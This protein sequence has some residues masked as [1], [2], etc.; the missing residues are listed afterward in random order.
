MQAVGEG[1]DDAEVR[2]GAAHAPE[3]VG[4]AVAARA[5]D[6]PVRR[7]D[8][9]LEEVV[10]RPAEAAAE[11]AQPAAERE[12]GDADA[13]YVAERRGEAVPLRGGIDLGERAAGT[14]GGGPRLRVD[15]DR[16][17]QRH[18]ERQSARGQRRAADVVA[19]PA[20]GHGQVVRAGVVERRGDV[21][22]AGRLDDERGRGPGGAVPQLGARVEARRAGDEDGAAHAAPQ[23]AEVARPVDHRAQRA[24]ERLGLLDGR[25]V[26]RAV[27][28]VQRP[29]PAGTHRRGDGERR[30]EVVAAPHER[31]RRRDLRELGGRHGAEREL[32][33]HRAERRA[34]VGGARPLQVRRHER[35]PRSADRG[36][37]AGQVMRAAVPQRLVR[38]LL[39]IL[40]ERLQRHPERRRRRERR[41]PEGVDEHEPPDAAGV[42]G[43]EPGRDRAAERLSGERGRRRARRVDELGEPAQD[44][45]RVEL[46][47]GGQGRALAREVRRDHPVAPGERG[48][49][50]PPVDGSPARPVQQHERRAAPALQHGGLDPG[51]RHPPA[52]HRDVGEQAALGLCEPH[53][54]ELDGHRSLLGIGSGER[55]PAA[56]PP[57]RRDHPF[58][59]GARVGS[60]V[61][62]VRARTRGPWP[63]RAWRRRASRRCC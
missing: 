6:A 43:G 25:I 55:P 35:R 32:L 38:G 40:G 44:E 30:G 59:R 7:D 28:H 10:D 31:R 26:G 5:A 24:R 45:L 19:A 37:E 21:G 12:P 57:H 58:A 62:P 54:I 52:A 50:A 1:G 33:H 56:R 41:E 61:R 18:V 60:P 48:Q 3:Q 53:R 29:A 51:E 14:D 20:H 39:R 49:D 23:R 8:L 34:G 17:E 27:D 46:G 13:R 16:S 47:A 22:R 42:G 11:V 15:L 9:H 4:L 36:A 63:P 2:A